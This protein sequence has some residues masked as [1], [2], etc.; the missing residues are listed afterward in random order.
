L[1]SGGELLA[2][3]VTGTIIQN[4]TIAG[5]N[6][7]NNTIAGNNIQQRTISNTNIQYNSISTT[8]IANYT[9][10][11]VNLSPSLT[12]LLGVPFGTPFSNAN[13][14]LTG[15]GSYDYYSTAYGY[16][17][18]LGYNEFYPGKQQAAASKGSFGATPTFNIAY[19]FN[20]T[21]NGYP[22]SSTYLYVYTNTWTQGGAN[23]I[24]LNNSG[25]STGTGSGV[26]IVGPDGPDTSTFSTQPYT[27]QVS[28]GLPN[29]TFNTVGGQPL[30]YGNGYATIG[31][32]L[33]NSTG[34]GNIQISNLTWSVTYP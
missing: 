29:N 6:I 13:V 1:I 17:K 5:N 22:T 32:A 33:T 24:Q 23:T 12:S 20:V 25:G 11:Y 15:T 26:F 4:N 9:I 16:V 10:Q 19:Q 21:G 31:L 8:E 2:N 14:S 18:L 28:L 27:G 3:T 30:F 7:Q 34:A